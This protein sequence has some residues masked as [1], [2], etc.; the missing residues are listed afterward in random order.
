MSDKSS[1]TSKSLPWYSIPILL[2]LL[3][4]I[5]II[6]LFAVYFFNERGIVFWSIIVSWFVILLVAGLEIG[7]Q[8]KLRRLLIEQ[9]EKQIEELKAKYQ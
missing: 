9:Q 4:A 3:G 1:M 2:T 5:S 8:E 6:L 7:R